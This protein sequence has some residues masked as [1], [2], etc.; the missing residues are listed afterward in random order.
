MK[1]K[2]LRALFVAGLL[3]LA[4]AVTLTSCSGGGGGGGGG[5]SPNTGAPNDE[6][7]DSSQTAGIKDYAPS[8]LEPCKIKFGSGRVVTLYRNSASIWDSTQS[9]YSN[10]NW[11]YT[12]TGANKGYLTVNNC[13]NTISVY[14]L[15]LEMKVS[16]RGEI[17][18]SE[19]NKA[20]WD[21]TQTIV[22]TNGK[23][24]TTDSGGSCTITSLQ[25]G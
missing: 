5:D 20:Y 9:A 12:K 25:Q 6:D 14:P 15:Y 4:P 10:G 22:D 2:R 13:S 23:V 7:G 21:Y 16:L 3:S 24:T 17:T 11:N 19:D 18:F 1:A 8:T